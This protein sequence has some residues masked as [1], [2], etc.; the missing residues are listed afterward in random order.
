MT[1]TMSMCEMYVY[2]RS[3]LSL[4]LFLHFSI[5]LLANIWMQRKFRQLYTY[6]WHV[7]TN[8]LPANIFQCQGETNNK[9]ILTFSYERCQSYATSTNVANNGAPIFTKVTLTINYSLITE[10]CLISTN[11]FWL[12]FILISF[13]FQ[14]NSFSKVRMMV[15]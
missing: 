10:N 14:H 4:S 5:I 1:M 15:V 2:V 3:S 11:I 7:R 9:A 8:Y 6:I 13:I 12:N